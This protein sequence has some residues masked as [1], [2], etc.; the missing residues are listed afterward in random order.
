MRLTQAMARYSNKPHEIAALNELE[1]SL[2]P[3]QLEHFLE[4]FLPR[5]PTMDEL[6][7][8]HEHG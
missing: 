2:T 3:E 4:A 7:K 5:C 6:R 8:R 1:K